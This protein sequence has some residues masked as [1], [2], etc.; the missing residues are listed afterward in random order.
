MPVKLGLTLI[1][2]K[3]IPVQELTP[4]RLHGLFFSLVGD[5]LAPILHEPRRVK[6]FTLSFYISSSRKRRSIFSE[7][8]GEAERLH[9]NVSFLEDALFPR[10]LYSYMLGAKREFHIGGHRLRALRRPNITDKYLK[11]Y[12]TLYEE[13][14]TLRRVMLEFTTPTVF[15]RGSRDLL[16]PEPKLIFKGL[17]RKWQAYSDLKIDIDLREYIEDKVFI[18]GVWIGSR[19]VEFSSGGWVGGFTGRVILGFDSE[20]ERVLKWLN[21]LARFA[22]F[23]GVGRKTT[24]G[25]GQVRFHSAL[26]EGEI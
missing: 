14:Q 26:P 2:E 15:R 3:P 4:D 23:A 19:R 25:F 5:T 24:M 11:S 7:R 13:A 12:S 10:F 22:E 20:E 18:S 21:T 1:P 9:M 6:P 8:E 17:I 16:L